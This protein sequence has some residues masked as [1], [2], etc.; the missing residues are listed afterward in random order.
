MNSLYWVHSDGNQ[1][2]FVPTLCTEYSNSSNWIHTYF[3][4]K[5]ADPMILLRRGTKRRGGGPPTYDFAENF[6]KKCMELR[7]SGSIINLSGHSSVDQES[8]HTFCVFDTVRG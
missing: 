6:Y 2:S 7:K 1:T 4:H 8:K 3:T 5:G